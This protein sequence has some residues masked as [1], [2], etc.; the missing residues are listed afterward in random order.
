MRHLVQDA[1]ECVRSV[2][3]VM[4]RECARVVGCVRADVVRCVSHT[5][6]LSACLLEEKASAMGLEPAITELESECFPLSHSE[7]NAFQALTT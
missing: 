5:A 3:F 2:C 1:C 7:L 6:F 4:L